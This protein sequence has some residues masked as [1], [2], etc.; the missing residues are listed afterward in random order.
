ME[1]TA[2]HEDLE[3]FRTLLKNQSHHRH[4][5]VVPA[6]RIEMTGDGFFVVEDA[7][8]GE[9]LADSLPADV[10]PEGT[11][12]L[13]YTA[14]SQFHQQLASKLPL[15]AFK[16]TYDYMRDDEPAL[17]A[18]VVNTYLNK[19][20]RRFLVRTFRPE[21]EDGTRGMMRA[22]LSDSYRMI[23]NYD[24]LLASA[25]AVYDEGL[26]ADVTCNLSTG[27]MWIQ[28]VFSDREVDI[29]DVIDLE[30]YDDPRGEIPS[31]NI[32]KPGFVVRN[33]EVGDAALEVRP[34]IEIQVCRNG[35]TRMEDALHRRHIG[36]NLKVGQSFTFS[37]ELHRE[38]MRLSIKQV[39]EV[40]GHFASEEY[41]HEVIAERFEGAD[42]KLDNPA[43]ALRHARDMLDIPE[44]EEDA[45]FEHFMEGGDTREVAVP[46]AIT[47]WAQTHE[48]PD[49]QY[50]LEAEAWD[51]L[52]HMDELDVDPEQHN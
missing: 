17:A 18:D 45:I 42:R 25:K 30:S 13:P 51:T 5:F 12:T 11:A 28:F 38:A 7:P 10:N 26:D 50:R 24:V 46:N 40:A 47:S 2:R 49:E 29:G 15:P 35:I 14:L 6:H 36:S 37:E 19:D 20:D 9:D 8:I 1:H 41:V 16:R 33:S 23:N 22:L 27:S 44:E 48:N 52:D 3:H 32:V 31:N 4:D 21:D 39:Q 43:A 34:R